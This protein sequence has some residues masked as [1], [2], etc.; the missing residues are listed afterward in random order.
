MMIVINL[1][2]IVDRT[3]YLDLKE[4]DLAI[5]FASQQQRL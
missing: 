2:N 1:Y 3:D 5:S 4:L